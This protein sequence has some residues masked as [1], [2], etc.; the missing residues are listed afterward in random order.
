MFEGLTTAL[1]T[2]FKYGELDEAGFRRLVRH[3]LN[4]GTDGILVA[5]CTGEAATLS[6]DEIQRLIIWADEEIR[7]HSRHAFLLAGTG[8]NSTEE[9]IE[10]TQAAQALGVDGVLLITPYYNKPS[11]EGLFAH[12]SEI[13]SKT[14][15]PLVLYNVPGRTGVNM[16]PKTV[17]KLAELDAVVAIKEAGGNLDQVSELMTLTGKITVLSGDDSLT[18]PMLAI[19]AHGVI[20]TTSNVDPVRMARLLACWRNTRL[21]EA[22]LVHGE[23]YPLIKAMFVESNPMP[24]KAALSLMGMIENELRLPLTT[25]QV[26]SF[27][28]I[29]RALRNAGL[30]ENRS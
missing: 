16:L 20:S 18:L 6:W 9:T 12:Y 10:R 5:G 13:A 17:A 3:Q 4:S 25:V 26:E 14:D 2:P 7:H 21:D 19:G 24:V 30:L 1:V 11:Q 28:T 29:E 22:R 23:L 8:L 27:P 15:V